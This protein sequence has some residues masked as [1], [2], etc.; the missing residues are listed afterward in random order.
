MPTNI[1][2]DHRFLSLCSAVRQCWQSIGNDI[3]TCAQECGDN[4]VSN[5][6]AVEACLD[7]NRLTMYPGGDAGKEADAFVS[8][9]A[10][11][12]RY[13]ELERAVAKACSL[14]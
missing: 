3:L 7:A 1:K 13:A 4:D 11:Q 2:H 5:L 10:S 12:G 6:A 9:C 8:E 14:N